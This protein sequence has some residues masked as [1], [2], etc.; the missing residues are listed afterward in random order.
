MSI[1]DKVKGKA[2]SLKPRVTE[3][4]IYVR[5]VPLRRVRAGSP[6]RIVMGSR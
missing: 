3:C 1:V 5:P 4:I 2:G 6:R